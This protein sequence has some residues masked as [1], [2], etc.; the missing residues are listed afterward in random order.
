[1]KLCYCDES[2]TGKEPI[3]VMTGILVDS[4]RMHRTKDNWDELLRSISRIS[5]RHLAELHTC[6]FYSGNGVFYGVDGHTR[7]RIISEIFEWLAKRKHHIAYTSVLKETYFK[8]FEA[9]AVPDE[10]NTVWRF[11]GFHLVLAIQ[12]YC[13]QE[14]GV[15]GNT[16]FI[17][18]NNERERMRFTDLI[19]RPPSWSDEYYDRKKKQDQLDQII[20]VPYFGDSKEVSLIQVA[21]F[22][23]YFLRRYAEL[24]EG[25]VK[26]W[27][28]DEQSTIEGWM[29]R[30]KDQSIG[31]RFIY[32]AVGRNAPENL[33]Y[34]IASPSIRQLR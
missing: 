27:Y 6:D 11:M 18:D 23:A 34:D 32:P 9:R 25:L 33:F 17:F 7:S 4:S 16:L 12:K 26:P 13:Q 28:S 29:K 24:K 31:T 20:D 5:G 15:K 3:A 14:S 1:M 2:G 8:S 21:D 30:F 19:A 22:L 10:L